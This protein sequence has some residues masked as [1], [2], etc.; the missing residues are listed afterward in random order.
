MLNILDSYKGSS[1]KSY[2]SDYHTFCEGG[3]VLRALKEQLQKPQLIAIR[4]RIMQNF[5]HGNFYNNAECFI[6]DESIAFVRGHKHGQIK[7]KEKG[8]LDQFDNI[9]RKFDIINPFIQQ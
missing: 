4:D 6:N 8:F 2:K 9:L 1:G 3:W 7:F 5:K